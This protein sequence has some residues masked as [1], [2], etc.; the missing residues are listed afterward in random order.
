MLHAG[1]DTVKAGV[2]CYRDYSAAVSCTIRDLSEM[3]ARLRLASATTPP[4]QF[5]LISVKE[6]VAFDAEIA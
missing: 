1:V 4:S 3:G 5:Y 2:A 6:A